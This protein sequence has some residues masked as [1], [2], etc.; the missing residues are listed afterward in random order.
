MQAVSKARGLS[1]AFKFPIFLNSD[2][3]L[4]PDV[5]PIE[6]PHTSLPWRNHSTFSSRT[7]FSSGFIGGDYL[8]IKQCAMYMRTLSRAHFSAKASGTIDG[9]PT[10]AVKESYDQMLQSV[11]VKRTMPP[12]AWLWSLIEN[13][14]NHDDIKLLFDILHNLRRFRLSN[15]RISSNFNCNLCREVTKACVRVEAIDFGKKTLWK[16]NIYGL[17]PSIASAHSL[18]LYAKKHNNA[19][20][21]KEIM[22]LLKRNDLPL[23]AGTAD[24]VFSICYNTNDWPLMSKYSKMFVKAGVKLRQT[25]FDMWMDFAAKIGDT[26]SL[27]KIEKLRSE[28]MKQ[29]TLVTGFSCAKYL[30]LEG[31]AEDAAAVIQVL[32]QNLPEAK[33]S[34][35]LVELQKL[36]NEW[37]LEVIKHQKEENKKELATSLKSDIPAMIN[38]LLK[39]GLEVTIN[40]EDLELTSKEGI[41][42]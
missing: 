18:L 25:S 21:M 26:E 34:N 39:N 12:N 7:S 3:F 28:S 31:K 17:T 16:H 20:L 24:I 1:R 33:K 15:L 4:A 29:H 2:R 13:C 10:E 22:K 23:Q 27:L 41:L 37:P 38:A 8:E 35:I 36:V 42:A 9:S 19:D 32:S 5:L 6:A 14:K 11:V 30:L 40:M